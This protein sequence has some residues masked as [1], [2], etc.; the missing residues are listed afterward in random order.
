MVNIIYKYN[1]LEEAKNLTPLTDEKLLMLQKFIDEGSS[2]LCEIEFS[3]VSEQNNGDIYRV[4]ANVTIDGKL[5]RAEA[6]RDSFEKAVDEVRDQIDKELRR[7]KGKQHSIA[8]RAGR[9]IKE[10]VTGS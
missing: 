6:I 9:K 4:E 2:V 7:A 5:Y 3:K 10:L 8:M 1:D